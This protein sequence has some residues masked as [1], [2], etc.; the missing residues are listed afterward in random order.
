M[1]KG[2]ILTYHGI[3]FI[4]G[5]LLDLVI[6]DPEGI[7]HPVRLIGSGI[8]FLDKKLYTPK[9]S[10]QSARGLL[11]VILVIIITV[12]TVFLLLWGCYW[13]HPLVGIVTEAVFTCY[14]MATRSLT[15]ESMKVYEQLQREDVEGA[16]RALSRIV[17]RDTE[18]LPV[19]GIVKATVETVAENTS[20][21]VIAPMLY[22]ALGG[23]VLGFFY[24]A[25]NTMDSMI[26]Y[27]NERYE[28]FGSP[29]A[30]LDDICNLLP[31]RISALWMLLAALLGG[32]D[33]DARRA[34]RIWRR[35]RNKTDSPNAGQTETVCAGALGLKLL[36]PAYY[37]GQRKDKACIGDET[38]KAEAEDIRKAN[39]L[40]LLTALIGMFFL[41]LLPAI[42]II[43]R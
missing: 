33:Y 17:G 35:D 43:G 34:W 13:L 37:F 40:M 41:G 7:F 31:A 11:L 27:R 42:A 25:V 9:E 28:R 36:G 5:F 8:A 1:I 6:G 20:D 38:R 32:R 10:S 2:T 39:R 21:G 19:E 12:L 22:T 30:R 29:A 4:A 14:L 26:G 15:S 23:P 18:R 3:A 24:K 16:R